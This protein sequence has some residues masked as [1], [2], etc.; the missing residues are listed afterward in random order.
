MLHQPSPVPPGISPKPGP[1]SSTT[2]WARPKSWLI[3]IVTVPAGPA[4]RVALLSRLEMMPRTFNLVHADQDGFSVRFNFKRAFV[5]NAL[6]SGGLV[7][8][9]SEVGQARPRLGGPIGAQPLPYHVREC[10]RLR[11]DLFEI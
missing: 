2:S 7:G 10:L 3:S 4:A 6:S 1:V 8:Q 5:G 9:R 11:D